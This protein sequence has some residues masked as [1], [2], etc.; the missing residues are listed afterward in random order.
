MARLAA[1]GF[2]VESPTATIEEPHTFETA[3]AANKSW[4]RWWGRWAVTSSGS[5]GDGNDT[6]LFFYPTCCYQYVT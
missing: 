6:G 2:L 4:R 3:T 1:L 5:G